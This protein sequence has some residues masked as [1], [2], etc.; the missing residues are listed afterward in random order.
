MEYFTKD[1]YQGDL[2]NVKGDGPQSCQAPEYSWI[3]F[4]LFPPRA[5]VLRQ[6]RWYYPLGLQELITADPDVTSLQYSRQQKSTDL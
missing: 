2:N 6:E 5:K 4:I 3:L 1:K